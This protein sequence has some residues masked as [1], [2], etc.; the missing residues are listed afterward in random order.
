MHPLDRCQCSCHV[1]LSNYRHSG[2]CCVEC[3]YCHEMVRV[4]QVHAHPARCP[5][6]PKPAKGERK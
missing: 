3:R 2:K 4:E 1:P 6:A 5:R